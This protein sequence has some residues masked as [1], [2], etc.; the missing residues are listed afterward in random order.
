MPLHKHTT[1]KDALIVCRSSAPTSL[2]MQAGRPYIHRNPT[3]AH[4]MRTHILYS[5][6]A[7]RET[8]CP[9]GYECLM[10]KWFTPALEE[11]PIAGEMV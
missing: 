7:S 2:I 3:A 4:T 6:S 11:P 9:A 1:F 8:E 5:C 10:L